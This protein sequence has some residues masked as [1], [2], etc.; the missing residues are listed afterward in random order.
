M[1]IVPVRRKKSQAGLLLIPPWVAEVVDFVGS[2]RRLLGVEK[3]RSILTMVLRC[4]HSLIAKMLRVAVSGDERLRGPM[5]AAGECVWPEVLVQF[6]GGGR[7]KFDASELFTTL[8]NACLDSDSVRQELSKRKFIDSRVP[9]SANDDA[10]LWATHDGSVFVQTTP[11]EEREESWEVV[12]SEKHL[13]LL[14]HDIKD[15]KFKPRLHYEDSEWSKTGTLDVVADAIGRVVDIAEQKV[16]LDRPSFGVNRE[17]MRECVLAI[18]GDIFEKRK[19]WPIWDEGERDRWLQGMESGGSAA[20]A[21]HV[22]QLE[23]QLQVKFKAV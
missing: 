11:G 13:N 1:I 19:R 14:K 21:F 15:F 10:L 9:L 3:G 18:E 6:L 4:S 5:D 2:F 23:K 12:S 17:S 7:S 22:L 8:M 20:L 16:D